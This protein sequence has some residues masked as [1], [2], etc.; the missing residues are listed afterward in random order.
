VLL[1]K[2]KKPIEGRVL[3]I[4]A[5]TN[6]IAFCI[7]DNKKIVKYGEINFFGQDVYDRI[8]DAKRKVAAIIDQFDADLVAIEAAVMV[9]SANTGLK[10][11]YIFGAIMAEVINDGKRVVEVH[12]ITWQ[13]YI[14]NTNFTK[15]Q[16]E[17]V[18]Q[19]FPGKSDNWYKAK[20]REM[21]KQ[22][23][24]DYFSNLGL[25]TDSDNVS[26]AAGVAWYV[27]NNLEKYS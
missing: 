24:M 15:A 27:S 17:S 2:L 6:S 13:S 8:V 14:G 23:T 1:K 21:R 19:K 26:D 5:S 20:I 11:A 7:I 12:P 4:D 10:M 9:R 22:I 16:K 3:G 18:R 25:S